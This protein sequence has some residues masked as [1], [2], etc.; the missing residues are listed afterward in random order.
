MPTTL[1]RSLLVV[2]IP[3]LVAVTPW[4]VVIVQQDPDAPTL[5]ARFPPLGYA[6]LF[7]IVAVT[8]SAIEEL[9]NLQDR[10]RRRT[11]DFR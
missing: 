1:T 5:L 6:L 3:G 11:A 7:A 8:G 4:L 9:A 10:C 2:L